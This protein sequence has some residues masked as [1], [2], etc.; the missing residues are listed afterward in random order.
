M[1]A[2]AL[3]SNE[4]Q[5]Y[6]MKLSGKELEQF[7]VRA[8]LY[9]EP[10]GDF[11]P[12]YQYEDNCRPGLLIPGT[13]RNLRGDFGMGIS[14]IDL[15]RPYNVLLDYTLSDTEIANLAEKGFFNSVYPFRFVESEPIAVVYEMSVTRY[16]GDN[17]MPVLIIEATNSNLIQCDTNEM[18]TDI[19]PYFAKMPKVVQPQQQDDFFF[20]YAAERERIAEIIIP[21]PEEQLTK[22]NAALKQMMEAVEELIAKPVTKPDHWVDEEPELS[23]AVSDYEKEAMQGSVDTPDATNEPVVTEALPQSDVTQ[24][25]FDFDDFDDDIPEVR[26]NTSGNSAEL[27]V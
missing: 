3:N 1:R 23:D 12:H 25:D 16:V 26:E 5:A 7:K 15:S 14:D 8:A 6:L 11:I 22:P 19:T 2:Y 13:V 21:E 4:P 9:V 24:D 17:K 10:A 20:D 18:L 27:D